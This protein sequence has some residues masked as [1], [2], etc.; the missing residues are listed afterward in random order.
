MA[1]PL[2][3]PRGCLYRRRPE[4]K[5][6]RFGG[7]FINLALISRVTHIDHSQVSRILR[8]TREPS[9]MQAQAIAKALAMDLQPFLDLRDAHT[10]SLKRT[11]HAETR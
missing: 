10:R 11:R 6:V 3:R 5:T 2:A 4:P 1:V 7:E 9:L 8:G